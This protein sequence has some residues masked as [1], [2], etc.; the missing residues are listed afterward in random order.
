VEIRARMGPEDMVLAC[1]DLAFALR[2]DRSGRWLFLRDGESFFRRAVDGR[3]LR[4]GG[5][6]PPVALDDAAGIHAAAGATARRFRTLLHDASTTLRLVGAPA[7]RGQLEQRLLA[8]ED[9]TP[10]RFAAES[11]RYANAYPEAMEI[12]PPDRYQNVVVQATQGCPFGRCSFCAFYRDRRF[13]A[14]TPAQLDAHLEALR[15][16]F[17]DALRLRSGVFLGAANALALAQPR[18]LAALDRSFRALPEVPRDAAAFWDPDH[19]PTRSASDWLALGAAGLRRV[20][21]GLE[22]GDPALRA[23]LGK[24]PDVPA[25]LEAVRAVRQSPVSLGLTILA[26]AGGAAAAERHRAGTCN[27][28]RDLGL[29]PE[30]IVYVS[31]LEG[32]LPAPALEAETRHFLHRLRQTTAA[33]VTPYRIRCFCYYA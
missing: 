12:L 15:L 17:G 24:S 19:A 25:F 3:V 33:K 26:G 27:A 10:E 16:L 32:P 13:R 23:E 8:V 29:R 1:E 5:A 6:T 22:S 18:L 28:I 9:W 11:V 4:A 21:A 2:A 31:P 14:L 7:D 20:V 30:D